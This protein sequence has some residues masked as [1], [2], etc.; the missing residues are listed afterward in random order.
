MQK[1][2]KPVT[3]PYKDRLNKEEKQNPL[4]VLQDFCDSYHLHEVKQILW[5]WLVTALGKSHSI[6]DEGKER[7]NLFFFYEK[8]ET[9]IE[10]VYILHEKQ[11]KDKDKQV[12]RPGS[13][14]K[15]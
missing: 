11:G 5:D 2:N 15:N 8:V 3:R 6:Y 12:K 1:S 10:A 14:N 13:R 4:P 7:S 9:L